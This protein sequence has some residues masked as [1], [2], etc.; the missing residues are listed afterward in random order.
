MKKKAG[1]SSHI[2]IGKTRIVVNFSDAKKS[3]C[4]H[5]LLT[6]RLRYMRKHGNLSH[7]SQ[8][9]TCIEPII[10]MNSSSTS[11]RVQIKLIASISQFHSQ[12]SEINLR[13]DDF[14]IAR[15]Q[16]GFWK[17]GRIRFS[18]LMLIIKLWWEKAERGG[19]KN[20]LAIFGQVFNKLSNGRFGPLNFGRRRRS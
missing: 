4:E 2:L 15:K 1:K 9:C 20:P 3:K 17:S 12:L 10:E 5:E 18:D 14:I 8:T 11:L 16:R 13:E 19:G 7:L 6:L